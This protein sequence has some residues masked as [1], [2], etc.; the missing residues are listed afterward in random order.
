MMNDSRASKY[1]CAITDSRLR[2]GE[3]GAARKR[4]TCITREIRNES[5]RTSTTSRW[6]ES[7]SSVPGC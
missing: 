3:P 2:R 4:C 1:R 5:V 7:V 6:K